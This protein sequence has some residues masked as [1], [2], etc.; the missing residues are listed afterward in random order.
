[1]P[2]SSSTRVLLSSSQP[3][4]VVIYAIVFLPCG[5]VSRP[6][7]LLLEVKYHLLNIPLAIFVDINVSKARLVGRLSVYI[8]HSFFLPYRHPRGAWGS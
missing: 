2:V 1:M 5:A 3:L 6:Q 8:Y 7:L 4:R